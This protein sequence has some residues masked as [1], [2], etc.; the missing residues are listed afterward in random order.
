MVVDKRT[1]LNENRE[2]VHV[3]WT[4]KRGNEIDLVGRL[5]VA[6][7]FGHSR[8]SARKSFV[9]SPYSCFYFGGPFIIWPTYLLL[10]TSPQ[11]V[12]WHVNF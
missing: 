3:R 10:L 9:C 12:G 11:S 8:G 2:R 1:V 5:N 4:A 7:L 6:W